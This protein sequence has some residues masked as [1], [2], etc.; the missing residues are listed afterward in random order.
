LEF[1]VTLIVSGLNMTMIENQQQNE[2]GNEGD[3]LLFA[4]MNL[5]HINIDWMEVQQPI[6]D[7][8]N[9]ALMRILI[10]VREPRRGYESP[11]DMMKRYDDY[12][13]AF[14]Q[15]D[16]Y[17]AELDQA[18]A[19]F[20]AQLVSM[21]DIVDALVY[22]AR[23]VGSFNPPP[24]PTF[25]PA[26]FPTYQCKF[27]LRFF[28]FVTRFPSPLPFSL[29]SCCLDPCLKFNITLLLSGINMTMIENLED[30]KNEAKA[31]LHATMNI[32]HI[33]AFNMEL[34]FPRPY[35]NNPSLIMFVI[36]VKEE[37]FSNMDTYEMLQFR[38]E[39]YKNNL[40][41]HLAQF[42]AALDIS[43]RDFSSQLVK[44]ANIEEV[45]VSGS[46]ITG[47]FSGGNYPTFSPAMGPQ[48]NGTFCSFHLP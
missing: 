39:W 17:N 34:D 11:M 32:S 8:N 18:A 7:E 48:G 9:P 31:I 43:A 38:Y 19:M 3:A 14:G 47:D 28:S 13:Q 40:V 27:S 46:F 42:N 23:I 10:K 22:S 41:S 15:L 2:G 21:V 33:N 5:T 36:H 44:Y 25:S 45:M 1:N 24:F 35:P 30:G 6:P 12:A 26:M 29:L 20:H 37:G 16:R 4:T